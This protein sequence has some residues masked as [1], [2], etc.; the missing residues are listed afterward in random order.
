MGAD[1]S[2]SPSGGTGLWFD[3]R[4]VSLRFVMVAAVIVA[5]MIPLALVSCVVEDRERY[6]N[7]AIEGIAAAWGGR[8]RIVGPIMVIPIDASESETGE[9]RYVAV[10]P[11]RVDVT[12]IADYEP[13]R[14]GIF[15]TPVFS[16]EVTAEGAFAPLDL[17][18]LQ[19]RFGTLRLDRASL[20]IGVSDPQGIRDATLAWERGE[21]S[22]SA[23]SDIGA[24]PSG[25]ACRVPWLTLRLVA[26][27]R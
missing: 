22:I 17:E 24:V 20:A 23:T 9:E 19:T 16:A 15:E 18:A 4:S 12:L 1:E 3:P 5:S 11:E 27:F 14:R 2:T 26:P 7:V 25:E 6:R 13:R 21:V 8:Q 10:M